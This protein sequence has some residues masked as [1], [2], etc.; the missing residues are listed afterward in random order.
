MNRQFDLIVFDWDGTLVDSIDW[1]VRCLQHAAAACGCPV[2]DDE[3]ARGIIG[4]SIERAMETLFPGIDEATQEQL[5]RIY[6]RQFFAKRF[7]RDDL[8]DGVYELLG[9]LKRAGY[10]LAVATGKKHAGLLEAMNATGVVG[11]FD[12]TRSAD[13]TASKPH[14]MMLDEIVAETNVSKDRA[15]M[16][17]DSVHDLQMAHNA[18]IAAIAVA[19]GAHSGATLEQYNPLHCLP[20]IGALAGIMSPTLQ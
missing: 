9:Q 4:L 13:Q 8:F 11:F 2:P 18:G 1:I 19:C 17:G 5:I 7:C 20:H 15:L 12:T 16:V 6:S 3:T 10:K 14:P